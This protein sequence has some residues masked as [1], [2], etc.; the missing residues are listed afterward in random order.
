LKAEHE[1]FRFDQFRPI[2]SLLVRVTKGRNIRS[3]ELGL[4]GNVGCRITWDPSRLLSPSARKKKEFDLAAITPQPLGETVFLYSA[5]PIWSALHP[6]ETVNRLKRVMPS[7]ATVIA[8]EVDVKVEH[9]SLTFPV[10]Q[11]LCKENDV[12][13]LE[14]WRNMGAA[15]VFDVQFSDFLNVLPGAEYSLGEVV[16]P[17]SDVI[18]QTKVG[19]WFDITRDSADQS[20]LKDHPQIY[21][22]VSWISPENGDDTSNETAREASKAIQEELLRSALVVKQQKDRL[23]LLS[24]SIG[25]FNTVRGISANLQMVQ[26]ALG[27]GLCLAESIVHLFDFTVSISF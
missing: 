23:G 11:P 16:V 22:E 18:N 25:A 3:F 10:L 21:L 7:S 13:F 4:P 1:V 14:P 2:G 6:S 12:L 24:G 17:V 9:D 15:L 8:S 26:N 20:V 5:S 27:K 19:G